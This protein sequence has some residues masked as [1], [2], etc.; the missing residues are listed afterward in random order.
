[1]AIG[2]LLER[3]SDVMILRLN[4]Q[5]RSSLLEHIMKRSLLSVVALAVAVVAVTTV[6]SCRKPAAPPSQ[7]SAPAPLAPAAGQPAPQAVKP[8]PTQLPDVLAKVNGEP[9]ERWE[10]ETALKR[11]E[12]RAQR[13]L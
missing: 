2:F 3:A 10:L 13:P 12:A 8:V 11:A 5:A 7:Q 4:T 6:A 9:I 1:M